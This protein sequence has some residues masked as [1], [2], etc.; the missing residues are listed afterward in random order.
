MR[1]RF[2]LCL[3]L[4][5]AGLLAGC[6]NGNAGDSNDE[7]NVFERA[8]TRIE[9]SFSSGTPSAPQPKIDA[10]DTKSAQDTPVQPAPEAEAE[11]EQATAKTAPQ[12][13][14]PATTEQADPAPPDAPK[15]P[16]EDNAASPTQATADETPANERKDATG[17]ASIDI[18]PVDIPYKKYVLDNGLTLIVHSD[19]KTP[20]VA[21]NIW[22][23]VGS[24]NEAEGQHGFA[25]LFEHLMFQG[26]EHWQGEY[27]EPFERAGATDMNGT[28][29]ADR[30]NYFA[31]VPTS[32][33]D[34][35]LWMESDRMG[36]FLGAI[37][38]NLLEEQRGVV[39]NE[40]R[41][42]ENQPYGRVFDTIPPNTYPAGHP[43]SWSTI[44]SEADLNAASLEDVK[45]WF[46]TYYGPSNAV[47]VLAGDIEPEAAKA[48]VE[49]YFGSIEPGPPVSQQK[50]WVAQMSGEHR[51]VMYDRVPQPRIYKVWNIPP[52]GAPDTTR[53]QIA[54]DL[55]AGSKNSPLYKSLVYDKQIATDVSAFVWDKEIGSQF[56]VSATA[57]PGVSLDEIETVLDARLRAFIQNGPPQDAV[58][59][60]RARF[61]ASFIRGVGSV[62]GIGGKAD[63]LAQGEIY[64]N[65][66]GA[67]KQELD[68]LRKATPDDIR[69]AAARWLTDG[70]Y[71]LSVEPFGDRKASGEDV[72]RQ[73][74]PDIGDTPALDLPDVQHA[75][76]SNGLKIRLAER[77]STP[78]VE[79]RMVFDAGYAADPADAPGTASLTMAMLDEGTNSRDALAISADLDR[80]G[81][82]LGTSTSLDSATLSLS[83]LTSTLD[84][85]LDIYADVLGNAAFPA[86]EFDRLQKQRLASIAQEKRQ[87]TSLALRTLGPL[88]Y[89]KDHAY[90]IPLTGSGTR[91]A[92]EQLKVDDIRHFAH[93]W[94]RPDNATLVV[95]GD[96]TMAELKP[97][98]EAHLGDWKAASDTPRPT[99]RLPEITPPDATHIYL[100]DRPGSNQATVIAGNVAPPKSSDQEIAMETVNAVLGGMFN[101]RLNLNLREDKHWSYGARS[102]LMDARAQQ[103]FVAYAAVQIDKTAP[104][105]Q[106]MR[107]ELT[108]VR[109]AR[110]ISE[111]ELSAAR[112][113]LTRSLPGENETASA[114]A[115]TLTDSVVFNLPDD[116]YEDYVRR[117]R[118]LDDPALADAAKAMIDSDGLTWVVVGDLDQ[119]ETAIR[120]LGWGKV[121]IVDPTTLEMS[122]ADDV[123]GDGDKDE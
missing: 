22:Y 54:A 104:A 38:Q 103:P 43:Y 93:T 88:L 62:G 14:P 31:S 24:K 112:A 21:V 18:P 64:E 3:T 35:A 15:Q 95:V 29:N 63:I 2:L 122:G 27:F 76:L 65:D 48:K 41:Q 26:S 79:M 72:D 114:L 42:G 40:K 90:G 105:M 61:G 4:A 73:Q 120:G 91:A 16:A 115:S 11:A 106:E 28:T 33:L 51:Q 25:H 86:N 39:L 32:A 117:I 98:L 1:I 108:G 77:H 34:M 53:L 50:R 109:D 6:D 67:Y 5:T 82:E 9:N 96:T 20:I 84:Q 78:M 111:S 8:W 119:I 92:I 57:R 99:K 85:S 87:P 116:Y 69:M 37:D 55:L 59:R 52:A 81:A 118:A 23:H 13:P 36:H 123:Q 30:T 56:I 19:H 66:P 101:S 83:T 44:G 12:T 107:Q 113:N 71:V 121:R 17:Q 94:L 45:Q 60:A 80:L 74:L 49:Q 58:E 47:L 7:A 10:A 97:M 89:G 75:T 100:V 70:V 110:P 102:L 46:K 68:I